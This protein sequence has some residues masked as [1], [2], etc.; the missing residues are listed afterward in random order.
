MASEEQVSIIRQLVADLR[1]IRAVCDQE[2]LSTPPAIG[3]R[4]LAENS[5][6]IERL[7]DETY[8]NTSEDERVALCREHNDL[9]ISAVSDGFR[10]SG[11]L[12]TS[13]ARRYQSAQRADIKELSEVSYDDLDVLIRSLEFAKYSPLSD[14]TLNLKLTPIFKYGL[15]NYYDPDQTR[16]HEHRTAV[17]WEIADRIYLEEKSKRFGNAKQQG[18]D[19]ENQFNF[20]DSRAILG[21]AQETGSQIVMSL[22]R[23]KAEADLS[24]VR[25]TAPEKET[26]YFGYLR[27]RLES[28]SQA[29]LWAFRE[30]LSRIINPMYDTLDDD[31]KRPIYFRVADMCKPVM[32]Q[33]S[34]YSAT[35]SAALI[36]PS[37][38]VRRKVL[39]YSRREVVFH[40][41]DVFQNIKDSTIVNKSVV[42]HWEQKQAGTD[43][44]EL[45][46]ELAKLREALKT[47][48]STTETD[49]AIGQVAAAEMAAKNNDGPQT[50][51]HLKNA[52]KWVLDMAK[53]IGTKVAADAI[54][55]AIG[56]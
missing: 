28:E 19:F 53:E 54:Q 3:V 14:S 45:Q 17:P 9:Y 42:E 21:A 43:L 44:A 6:L 22:L 36:Q 30:M 29:L 47:K 24:V 11:K 2:S 51:Q 41:G 49:M 5:T 23:T 4:Y 26:E 15:P 35:D 10:E 40:M 38:D 33:C 32:D 46:R 25:Q 50:F 8:T 12:A 16:S 18:L 55:K 34:L 20:Q 56:L 13:D 39:E 1:R 31:A 7:L 48:P 52:G 37:A 27:S